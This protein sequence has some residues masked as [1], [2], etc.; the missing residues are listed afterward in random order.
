MS[1]DKKEKSRTV[2]RYSISQDKTNE[3]GA[4]AGSAEMQY[5]CVENESTC[6]Q[7]GSMGRDNMTRREKRKRGLITRAARGRPVLN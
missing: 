7:T 2:D 4:N 6:T 1:N 5:E 3:N